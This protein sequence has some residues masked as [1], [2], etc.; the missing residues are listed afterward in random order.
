LAT[1]TLDPARPPLGEVVHWGVPPRAVDEPFITLD[2]PGRDAAILNIGSSDTTDNDRRGLVV[3]RGEEVV[4]P[5]VPAP[6]PCRC[7]VIV[8]SPLVAGG[9]C[10]PLVRGAIN[11]DS[12]GGPARRG[13]GAVA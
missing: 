3:E 13:G 11:A 4:R 9:P 6:M 2:L 1:I 5:D 8:A 10:P 7:P 12:R